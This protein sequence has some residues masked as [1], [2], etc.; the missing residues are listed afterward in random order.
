V[1]ASVLWQGHTD[2]SIS[3]AAGYY[4][5]AAITLPATAPT[6]WAATLIVMLVSSTSGSNNLFGSSSVYE[7][8][9]NGS[10]FMLDNVVSP[11]EDSAAGEI[12]YN[13]PYYYQI[14][15]V[16]RADIQFGGTVNIRVN[17]GQSTVSGGMPL[18]DAGVILA[19]VI[20]HDLSIPYFYYP[21]LIPLSGTS[22]PTP[23]GTSYAATVNQQTGPYIST[24]YFAAV[25]V[26][27]PS[28]VFADSTIEA[29]KANFDS[30][31]AHN[32]TAAWATYVSPYTNPN[33]YPSLPPIS[34]QTGFTWSWTTST[35]RYNLDATAVVVVPRTVPVTTR[36]R[37]Y[38]QV[39][40]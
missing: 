9:F 18:S 28:V 16:T 35:N 19:R 26:S 14:W 34:P 31:T 37:S 22:A 40:G 4:T 33:S 32:A 25:G 36:G 24:V 17:L 15:E 12:G 7:A 13:G 39:V 38:A 30:L 21:R 27:N 20:D 3:G 29:T 23:A 8:D 5:F 10:A 11:F 6:A 2:Y 1:P